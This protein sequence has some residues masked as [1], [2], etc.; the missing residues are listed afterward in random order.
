L[1][2]YG[3]FASEAALDLTAV[4][5]DFFDRVLGRSSAS[6][7]APVRYFLMGANQWQTAQTWPPT[8]AQTVSMFLTADGGLS[9]MPPTASA[10]PQRYVFDPTDPAPTRGGPTFLPGLFIGRNV[11]PQRPSASRPD[12]LTYCGEPLADDIALAGPVR[13]RVWF[14]TDAPSTDLTAK[15]IDVSLD[16]TAVGLCDGILRLLDPSGPAAPRQVLVDLGDIA[17][18]FRSGHRIRLDLSSSNYP[19]FDINP[20]TGE[21]PASATATRPAHQRVFSDA[22][23]LSTV[24]LTVLVTTGP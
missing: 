5:L 16:G 22:T 10:P 2:D 18:Q 9:A 12:V 14:A 17:Y 4:H 20:N 6:A 23:H 1:A 7:P 19:R 3:P 8:E 15:L 21:A 11:G 13:A 24:D